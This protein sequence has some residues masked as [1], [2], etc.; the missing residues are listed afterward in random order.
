MASVI[1]K[2]G[3]TIGNLRGRVASDSGRKTPVGVSMPQPDR[4]PYFLE[5]KSP[6][7]CVNFRVRQ[8]SVGRSFPGA[9]LTFEAR[10][11]GTVIVQGDGITW[12]E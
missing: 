12:L 7:L 4:H 9:A 8:Y 1:D 10:V 3:A 6:R 5:G 2:A 11:K